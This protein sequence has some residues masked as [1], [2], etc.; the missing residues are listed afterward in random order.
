MDLVLQKATELGIASIQPVVTA[1]SIVRLAHERRERRETHWQNV[2]IAACE[3]CGRNLVPPVAPSTG[4]PEFVALPARGGTRI[5]LAPDGEA[6][7]RAL[8]PRP[9]VTVLIGPEG[10]LAPEERDAR[11]RARVHRGAIRP[12]DPADGNGAARGAR[13][14]AGA[15]RRLLRARLLRRGRREERDDLRVAAAPGE[16]QR[17]VAPGVL[18]VRVDAAAGEEKLHRDRVP[19][20][21]RV[22]EL[23]RS[24]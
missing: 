3:Q 21:H 1:R 13:R 8:A 16:V 7:L 24:W 19:A 4:L 14:A 23:V 22:Q 20:L 12:A 10:G 5:L 9:P 18:R 6:T 15:V 17:G 2:V 11:R